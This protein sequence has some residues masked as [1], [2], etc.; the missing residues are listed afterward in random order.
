M[1]GQQATF[2]LLSHYDSG[3]LKGHLT[4]VL[5]LAQGLVSRGHRVLVMT[6][7]A[8]RADVEAAGA[9]LVPYQDYQ[10]ISERM[11]E[12]RRAMP[13]WA[14]RALPLR[15]LYQ[16]WH[17]RRVT[18]RNVEDYVRELEPVLRREHVD[19]MVFD[20]FT[21][22]AGY[23]A[24][25]L[26]IP[27]VSACNVAGVVDA[28]GLPLLLRTS[29]LGRLA[30][31]FPRLA[32]AVVD[33]LL[34]LRRVRS[35]MGLPPRQA[36]YAE[37]FQAMTSSQ[38]NIAMIPPGMLEGLALRDQQLFAGAIAF[39]G[40]KEQSDA[41][42]LPP[43]EPGTILVSTTTARND[44]GLLRRV[45]EALAPLDR[46]VL[47]T[48]AGVKEVP[49]GLGSHIRVERFVPH[50]QVLPQVTALVTHG[51][52]GAVSRAL[53]HGV[54]MLIIPLFFDQPLNAELLAA[55]GLA[56]H[57]PL[58]QATPEVIRQRLGALLEDKALHARLKSASQGLRSLREESV[59]L[60]A[61]ERL[62]LGSRA[63]RAGPPQA[64]TN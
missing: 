24:E 11:N 15:R 28:H 26:G 43:L 55:Q 51:G 8:A 35:R 25:P 42:P 49:R 47:A 13:G 39:N 54:P 1:T 17:M 60:N 56:Y 32:H 10:E 16:F 58:E 20:F 64:A 41:Q 57:L 59:A 7:G 52:W 37:Y 3:R 18:L 27:A 45:L 31:R 61:L 38:L 34:P 23:A 29:P 19:C 12:V 4:R 2:L 36:R 48:A 46:P 9:E 50:E 6:Q 21:L 5:D 44:E 22:G 14:R 33:A 63:R 53:R 30:N 62:A 40:S